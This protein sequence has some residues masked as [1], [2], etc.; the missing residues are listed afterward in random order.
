[1]MFLAH[2]I[3]AR[4]LRNQERILLREVSEVLLGALL[5]VVHRLRAHEER[6]CVDLVWTGHSFSLIICLIGL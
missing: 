5:V 3:L 2:V 1:M 4:H 6:S